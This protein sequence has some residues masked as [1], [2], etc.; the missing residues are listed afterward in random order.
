VPKTSWKVKLLIFSIIITLIGFV[1]WESWF[2]I[3]IRNNTLQNLADGQLTFSGIFLLVCTGFPMIL[4]YTKGFMQRFLFLL[5]ALVLLISGSIWLFS[6]FL[7]SSKWSDEYV[8]QNGKDYMIVQVLEAGFMDVDGAWR[9]VRTASP[10]DMIRTLEDT[11]VIQKNDNI[12]ND[13]KTEIT[14]A[15][16]T[17]HKVSLPDD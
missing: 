17:W 12:Y 5:F 13:R 15:N 8:Y 9:I 2:N 16:K 6:F 10:T 4:N 3:E 1:Q 7:P 11:Q 14:F